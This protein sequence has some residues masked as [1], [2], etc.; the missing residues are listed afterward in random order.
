MAKKR[1][2]REAIVLVFRLMSLVVLVIPTRIGLV[3]GQV[4]GRLSYYILGKERRRAL[5]NLDI[6]FGNSKSA[7]EKRNIVKKVFENLGKNLVEVISISKFNNSGIKRYV[8]C[9]NIGMLRQFLQEGKAVIILS[10]HFGNWEFLAHYLSI[11]G[12][13]MNVIARRARMEGLEAFLTRIRKQNGVNI[14]YRDA[15][16]KEIVD[17]LKSG[18]FVGIMPDQDMDSVSGVFV[19]F[20]GKK[21]WTPSGPAVLN[22]LTGAP[23]L[24]CFI[25][26]RAYGHEILIQEP[27]K[28]VNTGDKRSD[29]L[30]NAQRYTKVIEDQ[31]RRFPE[32]WV[33]FHDRWK[34]MSSG[35]DNIG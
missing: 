20:F 30:E 7:V 21:A 35:S 28:L 23:I 18:R 4:L 17:L 12:L 15:P 32:H 1:H 9:R 11:N 25:V 10:A 16:A 26:R 14:L 22:L 8:S 27:V 2:R 33:W 3:I 5:K 29:M 31:I 19:D 24:P 6:A 34:T 13:P